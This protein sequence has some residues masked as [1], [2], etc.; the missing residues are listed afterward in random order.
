MEGNDEL[1]SHSV[2]IVIT[3][4]GAL[5]YLASCLETWRLHTEN[6]HVLLVDDCE[7]TEESE[8]LEK[9]S[10]SHK[11]VTV[12]AKNGTGSIGYVLCIS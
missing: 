8:E 10:S 3:V 11:N 5:H 1:G 2:A 12:V 9:L 7:T 6:S 4:H